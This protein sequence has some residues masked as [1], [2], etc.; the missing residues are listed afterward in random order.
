[1][2]RDFDPARDRRAR[3]VNGQLNFFGGISPEFPQ[4][5]PI[6]ADSPQE[7]SEITSQVF[8]SLRFDTTFRGAGISGLDRRPRA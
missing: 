1:M 5:H 4:L 3:I 6:D 8:Q 7:C 2:S